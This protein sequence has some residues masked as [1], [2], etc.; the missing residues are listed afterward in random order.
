MGMDGLPAVM[1]SLA[2][3]AI[4]LYGHGEPKYKQPLLLHSGLALQQ[5]MR[6]PAPILLDQF[7]KK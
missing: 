1:P 4:S 5:G 7:Y 2:A 6:H 3:P